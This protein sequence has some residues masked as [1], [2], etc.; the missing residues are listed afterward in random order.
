MMGR[1]LLYNAAHDASLLKY[2]V[3]PY[4]VYA[5][6]VILANPSFFRFFRF[7]SGQGRG[8]RGGRWR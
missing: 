4:S 7:L 2:G 1:G 6:E 5:P 3:S 8:G